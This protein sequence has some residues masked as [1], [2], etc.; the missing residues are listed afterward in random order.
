MIGFVCPIYETSDD[1][2]DIGMGS[3]RYS[4]GMME[5][6][7]H[8]LLVCPSFSE[9]RRQAQRRP[10]RNTLTSGLGLDDMSLS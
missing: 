10:L 6:E 1:N 9:I 3:Y 5:N 2:L 4:T 8:F 7:Y